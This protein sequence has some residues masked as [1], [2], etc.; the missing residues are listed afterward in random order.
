M[1]V[2]YIKID[3][4]AT[5]G[6]KASEL[7]NIVNTVETAQERLPT[8]K[9]QMDQMIDNGDYTAIETHYKLP[10]GTGQTVYNLV[11][12]ALTDINST[13]LAQLVQRLG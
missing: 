12:G 9:A 7:Q 11:A 3:T 10:T 1:A 2:E 6:Q 8:I 13:N 4:T 5:G